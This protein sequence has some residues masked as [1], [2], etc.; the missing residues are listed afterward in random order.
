VSQGT[1]EI[2]FCVG[3]CRSN[4]VSTWRCCFVAP[5]CVAESGER[6]NVQTPKRT[7]DKVCMH[8]SN[9][10]RLSACFSPLPNQALVICHTTLWWRA[11]TPRGSVDSAIVFHTPV[12]R[13]LVPP[14]NH[15]ICLAPRW[16]L[17]LR[18]IIY[19]AAGLGKLV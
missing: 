17:G 9:S 2:S 12:V 5:V 7:V 19:F 15:P 8:G 13:T 4:Q 11:K 14:Y 16:Y 1:I 10:K 18:T 3:P 6:R